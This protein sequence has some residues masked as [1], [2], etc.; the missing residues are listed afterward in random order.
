MLEFQRIEYFL[1]YF[2]ILWIFLG[3][4]QNWTIFGGHF[5][6][7]KGLFLKSRYRKGI[8]FGFA[9]FLFFWYA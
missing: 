4:S 2:K 3:S 7:F 8:I 5:F 1:G 6:A 9:I